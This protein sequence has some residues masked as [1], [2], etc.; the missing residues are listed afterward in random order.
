MCN[1]HF[2][3]VFFSF[4]HLCFSLVCF[5]YLYVLVFILFFFAVIIF[6]VLVVFQG[7]FHSN[8]VLDFPN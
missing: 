2:V 5:I 1:L 6:L 7:F 4:L 8:M 3:K